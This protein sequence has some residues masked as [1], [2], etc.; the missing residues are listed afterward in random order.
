MTIYETQYVIEELPDNP[1]R[2]G[3]H[4]AHAVASRPFGIARRDVEIKAQLWKRQ[5]AISDQGQM[6]SCTAHAALGCLS[7]LPYKQHFRSLKT[8]QRFYFEETRTDDFP[9]EMPPDDTGSDG[10][11][12]GKVARN[13]GYITEWRHCFGINDVLQALQTGPVITGTN[14][15]EGMF[16][17]DGNGQ[18]RINGAV[19]GG[20]EWCLVGVNPDARLLRAA[21]SWGV[22]W[23]NKGF[24]TV[25][26][27]DYDRLLHEDGDATVFIR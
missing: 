26:Y 11:T 5:V 12:A 10:N 22:G 6:G 4:V 7:T 23:G 24:F 25:S 2:L 1:Y 27:D 3:R 21:N 14:W 17:P 13:R 18:V 19:A 9:G 20:H 15:Y 16:N 8:I